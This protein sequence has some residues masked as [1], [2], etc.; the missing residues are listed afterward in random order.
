MKCIETAEESYLIDPLNVKVGWCIDANGERV[1]RVLRPDQ[2]PIV[3]LNMLDVL[4]PD[5]SRF[6][7]E[8]LRGWGAEITQVRIAA[9]LACP[10]VSYVAYDHAEYLAAFWEENQAFL[11]S[12]CSLVSER[13]RLLA[14]A[15]HRVTGALV[16]PS[17]GSAVPRTAT[18]LYVITMP[19]QGSDAYELRM[20]SAGVDLA[21]FR[22]SRA[23]CQ[24]VQ[25][26][27]QE[28]PWY[29]T[30]TYVQMLRYLRQHPPLEESAVP[31]AQPT[32][33]I[34]LPQEQT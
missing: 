32:R 22:G 21:V 2:D 10:H 5:F 1:V 26:Y 23:S 14:L 12:G 6:S 24:V 16:V 33:A 15:G 31:Q 4:L 19:R 20:M 25:S 3:V 8:T 28:V 13:I 17:H 11:E 30:V 34:N 27:L 7:V 9:K 18:T 29:E